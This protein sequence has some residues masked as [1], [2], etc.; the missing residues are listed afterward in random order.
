MIV[1]KRYKIR[2]HLFEQLHSFR[3][4]PECI[5]FSRKGFSSV[6][7]CIFMIQK[8]NVRRP[9][10]IQ[11]LRGNAL[12]QVIDLV[13]MIQNKSVFGEAQISCHGDPCRIRS[14]LRDFSALI[15]RAAGKIYPALCSRVRVVEKSRTAILKHMHRHA[16]SVI[17][18]PLCQFSFFCNGRQFPVL[19][20]RTV[21]NCPLGKLPSVFC[22]LSGY[23]LCKLFICLCQRRNDILPLSVAPSL[24]VCSHAYHADTQRHQQEEYPRHHKPAPY[25]SASSRPDTGLPSPIIPLML[26]LPYLL[27]PPHS[28]VFNRNRSRKLCRAEF[29]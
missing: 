27:L 28:S 18:V 19:P 6:A 20:G 21:L 17:D 29:S 16:Q 9:G 12:L 23:R 8:E 11:D 24:P 1:G 3:F 2:P 25:L 22:L 7:D 13:I 15:F 5:I 26:H 10:N 14:R 4:C